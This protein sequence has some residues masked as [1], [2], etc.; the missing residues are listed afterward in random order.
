MD[1]YLGA[2]AAV[3]RLESLKRD[4][5]EQ[6]TQAK[7]QAKALDVRDV[8]LRRGWESEGANYD[9]VLGVAQSSDVHP[10]LYVWLQLFAVLKYG[11]AGQKYVSCGSC[12]GIR[13]AL[14]NMADECESMFEAV[15]ES[16]EEQDTEELPKTIRVWLR[17]LRVF[18]RLGAWLGR[19]RL[20]LRLAL[21]PVRYS[22]PIPGIGARLAALSLAQES[23]F[24]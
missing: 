2:A 12:W 5:D 4:I 3:E 15:V 8:L 14:Y 18:V 7:R 19:A 23:R 1:A 10:S 20:S 22:G 13:G 21:G 11:L 6:L 24:F 16:D 9:S 17:C